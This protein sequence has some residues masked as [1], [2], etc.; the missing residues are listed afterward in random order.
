MEIR[1]CMNHSG[2]EGKSLYINRTVGGNRVTSID[3]NNTMDVTLDKRL[4][5]KF[6][7]KQ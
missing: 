2:E 5:N 3:P 4:K 1:T 7:A 6:L